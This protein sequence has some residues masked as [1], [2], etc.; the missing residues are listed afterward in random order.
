MRVPL[1]NSLWILILLAISSSC[2]ANDPR[3]HQND[4]VFFGKLAVPRDQNSGTIWVE[5]G[6]SLIV[7]A[8]VPVAY[9][10]ITESDI[11]FIGSDKT[12]YGFFEGVFGK[13]ED[14]VEQRFYSSLSTYKFERVVSDDLHFLLLSSKSDAHLYVL[15]PKLDFALDIYFKEWD[16][17]LID[18]ITHG[19]RMLQGE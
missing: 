6:P 18:R 2:L 16:R 1:L 9:N 5:R 15:S 19:A 8:K 14:A 7:E 12:P 11:A 13:R 10:V 3:Q 17:G 4:V